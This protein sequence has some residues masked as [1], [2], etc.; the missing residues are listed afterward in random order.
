MKY[1]QLFSATGFLV[2]LVINICTFGK[3]PYYA[4]VAAL[5]LLQLGAFAA[6][7][8]TILAGFQT[9][10]IRW[11]WQFLRCAPRWLRCV[12]AVTLVYCFVTFLVFCS[13]K[14]TPEHR[15]GKLVLADGGKIVKELTPEEFAWYRAIGTRWGS[16]GWMVFFVGSWTVLVAMERSE[17]RNVLKAG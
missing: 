5:L 10:K 4:P 1:F 6:I 17:D 15:D 7:G 14:G 16:C 13:N 11:T 12:A 2:S 8:I 3:P 9:G